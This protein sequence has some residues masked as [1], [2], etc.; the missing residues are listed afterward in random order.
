M[1]GMV[2]ERGMTPVD[3]AAEK[4]RVSIWHA[5]LLLGG[6]P[7]WGITLTRRSL[8]FHCYSMDDCVACGCEIAPSPGGHWMYRAH[9]QVDPGVPRELPPRPS[10]ER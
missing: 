2:A 5:C 9:A 4:G 6:A 10:M 3:S 8:V 1:E 7:I